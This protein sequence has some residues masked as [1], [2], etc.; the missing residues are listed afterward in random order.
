[1]NYFNSVRSTLASTEPP[2]RPPSPVVG[3][4]RAAE[5]ADAAELLAWSFRDNPLNRAVIR[6]DAARRLRCNRIGMQTTFEAVFGHSQILVARPEAATAGGLLGV[7][8]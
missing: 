4:L 3:A 2:E 1:M 5:R 8:L 6:G 7:L